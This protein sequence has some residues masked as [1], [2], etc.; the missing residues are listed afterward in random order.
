MQCSRLARE[1]LHFLHIFGR[2]ADVRQ[3]FEFTPLFDF[4]H[5]LHFLQALVWWTAHLFRLTVT[6]PAG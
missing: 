3:A 5:F 6:Q 1:F 4:L 2:S